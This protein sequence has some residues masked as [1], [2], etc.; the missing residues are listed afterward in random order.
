M[1][2]VIHATAAAVLLLAIRQTNWRLFYHSRLLQHLSLGGIAIL[3]FVWLMSA[4]LDQGLSIHFLGITA[5]T[6]ML[7]YRRALIA[8]AIIVLINQSFAGYPWSAISSLYLTHGVVPAT[9][10]YLAYA[11]IYHRLPRHPFVYLF[12]NAFL[13]GALAIGFTHLTHSLWA[14]GTGYLG[15]DAV[16][17]NYA[18]ITPLVMF[19]EALLNGMAVTLMVVYKPDWLITFNDAT[20]LDKG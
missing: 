4:R 3:S 10:T 14:W 6:L 2:W 7:G 19:P 8:S 13:T 1:A 9:A 15:W 16:W 11:V 5:L 18:L 20:Y 12:V 17:H